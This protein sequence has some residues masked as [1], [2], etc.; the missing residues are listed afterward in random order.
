MKAVIL[1]AFGSVDQFD[2][3]EVPDPVM[4]DNDLLVRI[5]ATAFNPI[6]YQMRRGG[7]EKKLLS[8]PILGREFSG[9][10]Q[11][12][13]KA[14]KS[15]APGDRIAANVGSLASNGTYAE[16]IA[17]P[18]QLV[19]QIP[20]GISF[21]QAAALP[22]VGLTALQCA[23]RLPISTDA[24]IFISGGA[25]GVGTILI[26]LLQEAGFKNM[27][28]T[29]GN[30]QSRG[31]LLALGLPD[32]RVIDYRKEEVV[33]S[34]K[35]AFDSVEYDCCIDLVG[36]MMSEVCAELLRVQGIYVDI[37]HLSSEAARDVLFDKAATV[38]HIANYAYAVPGRPDLYSIYGKKLQTLFDRI[39]TNRIQPAPIQ[40][41]GALSADTVKNAHAL[42][43]ANESKG[44]K[45]VMIM[46]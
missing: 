7:G 2:L 31:H 10:V 13:G 23:E 29:A 9:T 42:L 18:Q 36:G 24:R 34:A 43:E 20:S 3:A 1:K 39:A 41:V 11:Q 38:L 14:V 37:T 28:T 26:Q 16:L 46:D 12:V 27:V 4:G 35:A 32:A 15:F 17:V 25:G 45:L 33:Q 22:L 8:S 44:Q 6:D 40:I 5:G 30:V 21:G 19:A